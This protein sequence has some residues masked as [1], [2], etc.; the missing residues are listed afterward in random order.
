MNIDDLIDQFASDIQFDAL[1]G[2]CA[3]LGVDYELPPCDD[4]YPD[5][6]DEI[7]VEIA[8][9]MSEVGKKVVETDE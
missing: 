9:A 6:E 4:M 5:W 1:E 3:I 2:W 8:H 7:R